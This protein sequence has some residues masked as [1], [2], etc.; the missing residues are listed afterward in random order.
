MSNDA[1]SRNAM[2]TLLSAV[3]IAAAVAAFQAQAIAGTTSYSGPLTD[4]ASTGISSA[5]TYTHK[6]SGG[7][8]ASIN[9]VSLDVLSDTATPANFNWN[10]DGRNKNVIACCNN[11]DWQPAM[12]GV[13]GS[14]LINLLGSFTYSGN[15]DG[16]PSHQVFTLSG[17]DPGTTYDARLYVRV[18]DTE[19]SGRPIDL[20]FTN[21]SEIDTIA[22]LMED[23]PSQVLGGGSDHDAYYV[24]Y[25]YTAQGSDL[26]IDA[27]VVGAAP[28][29][30]FHMYALTNEVVPEPSSLALIGS[31]MLGMLALGRRR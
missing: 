8:A 23:R 24:N 27:A 4:N 26:L 11:G 16:T 12:G 25:R 17:L 19:A 29:G 1:N 9:G 10:T 18:W 5:K 3:M 20:T 14:E 21:G 30:S 28:S 6:I 7:T 13:T 15:G 31:G 22:S 2:R